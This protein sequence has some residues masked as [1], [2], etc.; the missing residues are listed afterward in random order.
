MTD[1]SPNENEVAVTGHLAEG[2]SIAGTFSA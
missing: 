2:V 1:W